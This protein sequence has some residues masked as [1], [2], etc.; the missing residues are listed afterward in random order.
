MI[1]SSDK[2][3]RM[4][5]IS[6]A[7]KKANFEKID[8]VINAGLECIKCHTF[9]LQKTERGF[10]LLFTAFSSL[11]RKEKNLSR[12]YLLS[13]IFSNNCF[14]VSSLLFVNSKGEL[15]KGSKCTATSSSL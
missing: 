11:F 13:L 12:I 1:I 6:K 9:H 14:R 8:S 5:I 7:E 3:P 10:P 4:T 15:V 2:N